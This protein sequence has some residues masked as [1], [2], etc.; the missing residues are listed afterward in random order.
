M[1]CGSAGQSGW[2]DEPGQTPFRIERAWVSLSLGLDE[3][4]QPFQPSFIQLQVFG[5]QSGDKIPLSAL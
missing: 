1:V 4:L 2:S 3:R 5:L